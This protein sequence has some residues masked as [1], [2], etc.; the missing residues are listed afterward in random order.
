MCVCVCVGGGVC[1]CVRKKKKKKKNSLVDLLA[2]VG[3][4][5]CVGVG[6][7]HG[8]RVV[9]LEDHLAGGEGRLLGLQ[10]V[11]RLHD[12]L[13]TVGSHADAAH[14]LALVVGVGGEPHQLVALFA[15]TPTP[16]SG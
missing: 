8:G 5:V 12:L 9:V 15:K 13:R 2:G 11:V 1:V 16:A 6:G 4:C 10:V 3:S 14:Q 7:T